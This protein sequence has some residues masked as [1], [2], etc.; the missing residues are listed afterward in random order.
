MLPT[1]PTNTRKLLLFPE[2]L[3]KFTYNSLKDLIDTGKFWIIFIQ[4]CD[5]SWYTQKQSSNL[6]P[7]HNKF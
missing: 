7:V 4:E 5:Y 1:L 6:T 2:E 3:E